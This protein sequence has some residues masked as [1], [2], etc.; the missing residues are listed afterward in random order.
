MIHR[1][2]A[3]PIPRDHDSPDVAL[4]TLTKYIIHG[5]GMI[6]IQPASLRLASLH[7][8]RQDEPRRLPANS[9][10]H[11]VGLAGGYSTT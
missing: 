8:A 9:R 5:A 6:L 11:L 1:H 7:A 2:L 10:T 4:E 3:R